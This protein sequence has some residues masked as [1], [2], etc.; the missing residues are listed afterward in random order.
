MLSWSDAA[1][2][3]LAGGNLRPA[4]FFRALPRRPVLR[5]W[6]GIGDFPVP[7]RIAIED[8]GQHLSGLRRISEPAGHHPADQRPG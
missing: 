7:K 8:C 4:F 2:A 5:V 1:Q 3:Q 6:V